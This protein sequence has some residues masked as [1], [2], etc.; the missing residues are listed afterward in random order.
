M[1]S[2]LVSLVLGFGLFLVGVPLALATARL[3]GVYTTVFERTAKVFTLFGE[4]IGTI[5]EPGLHLLVGEARHQGG[6]GAAVRQGAH[7]RSAARPT[8]PAQPAGELGGRRSDGHRHLV[9]NGR[10]R[11]G[12]VPLQE[13]RPPRRLRANVSN[14]AVR[15]L[16]NMKLD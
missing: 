4:V 1:I 11:P 2:F 7:R 6:A 13:R 14:A 5:D 15:A 16:S 9:R 3:L 10:S 12:G 8:V